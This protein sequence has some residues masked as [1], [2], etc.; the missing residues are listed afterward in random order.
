MKFTKKTIIIFSSFLIGL[1]I[2]TYLIYMNHINITRDSLGS[3]H[4]IT[5]RCRIIEYALV[6]YILKNSDA[7]LKS[8]G[9]ESGKTN[10][11]ILLQKLKEPV[12]N[13]PYL[14]KDFNLS[15]YDYG[16]NGF[17]IEVDKS[18]MVV[19]VYPQKKSSEC[20]VIIND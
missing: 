12:K 19:K 3:E 5:A 10:S 7:E 13:G 9:V 18:S 17:K 4:N 14:N 6:A 1:S 2:G 8:L 15:I 11:D 16:Y 20:I